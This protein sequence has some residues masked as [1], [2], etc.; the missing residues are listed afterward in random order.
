[1]ASDSG[2]YLSLVWNKI[3]VIVHFSC[4]YCSLLLSASVSV[5]VKLLK[6]SSPAYKIAEIKAQTCSTLNLS[7]HNRTSSI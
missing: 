4:H 6:L 2:R 7:E 3:F 5:T 1:M